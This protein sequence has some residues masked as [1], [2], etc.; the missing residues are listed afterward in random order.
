MSTP[1][2][3]KKGSAE[4]PPPESAAGLTYFCSIIQFAH[5]IRPIVH[6]GLFFPNAN[7]RPISDFSRDTYRRIETRHPFYFGGCVFPVRSHHIYWPPSLHL[8]PY[9]LQLWQRPHSHFPPH[10]LTIAIPLL[11]IVPLRSC[12]SRPQSPRPPTRRNCPEA[13]PCRPRRS[14]E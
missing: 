2:D 14:G 7:P 6:R 10:T 4:S 1:S 5:A 12:W 13:A 8:I 9:C 11:P 3:H